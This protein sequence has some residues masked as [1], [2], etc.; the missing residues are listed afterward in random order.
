MTYLFIS[1]GYEN[2][3]KKEFTGKSVDDA[4]TNATVALGVTSSEIKYEVVE[5]YKGKI[6]NGKVTGVYSYKSRSGLVDQWHKYVQKQMRD[7]YKQL[8]EKLIFSNQKSKKTD[9]SS[10][11]LNYP[12][13]PGDISAYEK[14]VGTL[15]EPEEKRKIEWAIGCIVNGDSKQI[16]KF[17]VLYGSAG[18]GKSTVLNIIQKLFEG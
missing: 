7:H 10:K 16:Q 4:I 8:D 2:G 15:Y 13:E 14:L 6:P 9:Y 1:G 11:Q 17:L 3:R 5:E 12:L 18:T